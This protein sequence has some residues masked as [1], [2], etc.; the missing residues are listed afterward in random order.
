MTLTT[1]WFTQEPPLIDEEKCWP[2]FEKSVT[3]ALDAVTIMRDREGETI[4]TDLLSGPIRWK[5]ISNVL[6][7]ARSVF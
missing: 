1:D 3:M 7:P 5:S 6:R 2:V 4:H